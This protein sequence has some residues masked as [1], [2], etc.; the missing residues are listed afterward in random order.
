M[1]TLLGAS[2]VRVKTETPT[3]MNGVHLLKG[4]ENQLVVRNE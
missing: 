3:D 2:K 1:N 4:L